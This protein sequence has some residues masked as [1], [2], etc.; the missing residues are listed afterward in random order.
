MKTN[1]NFEIIELSQRECENINGGASEVTEAVCWLAGYAFG[2]FAQ[3]EMLLN[4]A[5]VPL[6]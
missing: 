5:N 3:A 6:L 2:M 4:D 1:R